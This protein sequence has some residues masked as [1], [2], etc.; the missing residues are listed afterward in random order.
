MCWSDG[1]LG[2]TI[3]VSSRAP[4]LISMRRGLALP[5]RGGYRQHPVLIG[6]G[7]VVGVDVLTEGQATQVTAGEALGAR[8]LTSC[9]SASL[10]CAVTVRSR[11]DADV[12]RI[13]V[14]PEVGVKHVMITGA[15]EVHGMASGLGRSRRCTEQLRGESVDVAEWIG[16]KHSNHLL[17]SVAAPRHRDGCRLAA[18]LLG[19]TPPARAP[20]VSALRPGLR[21]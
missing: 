19:R 16:M 17:L 9:S 20:E 13:G 3:F 10:R 8:P 7:D 21:R 6:G 4:W 12:H 2:S 15:V 18:L 14:H 11:V 1:S 5:P